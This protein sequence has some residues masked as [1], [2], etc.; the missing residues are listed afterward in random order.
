MPDKDMNYKAYNVIAG[1]AIKWELQHD[2]FY[3]Y[4]LI[5]HVPMNTDFGNHIA[6]DVRIKLSKAGFKSKI[7]W[8]DNWTMKVEVI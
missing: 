6:Q 8:I 1:V 5:H 7:S 4:V 2:K 3:D